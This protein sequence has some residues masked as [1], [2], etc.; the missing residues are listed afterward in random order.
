MCEYFLG[1]VAMFL[2]IPF[3]IFR[4]TDE[5]VSIFGSDKVFIAASKLGIDS[6]GAVVA[7]ST[8]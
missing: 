7:S 4:Q 1:C 2:C 3:S 6:P 5:L 8:T